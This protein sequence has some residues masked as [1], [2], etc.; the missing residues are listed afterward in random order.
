[1][2]FK[3][4]NLHEI[5]YDD[6]DEYNMHNMD[7]YIKLNNYIMNLNKIIEKSKDNFVNLTPDDLKGNI[8]DLKK[9]SQNIMDFNTKTLPAVQA[10]MNDSNAKA[11][12]SKENLK[13]LL[14][15]IYTLKNLEIINQ[16]NA[17]SYHEYNKYLSP[18]ANIFYKQYL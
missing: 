10:I 7:D 9:V 1:M 5:M 6:E 16:Q 11:Y 14:T 4:Y 13:K 12:I 18:T 15:S 2:H 17:V 8:V 3:M